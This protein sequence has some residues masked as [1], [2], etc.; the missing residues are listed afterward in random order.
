[1]KCFEQ[2]SIVSAGQLRAH[3]LGEMMKRMCQASNGIGLKSYFA[4]STE[5]PI[6]M[7]FAIAEVAEFRP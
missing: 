7:R 5:A 2:Q 6:F 3:F 4:E 1:M